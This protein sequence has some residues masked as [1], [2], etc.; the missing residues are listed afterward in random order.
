MNDRS[1]GHS[2]K[3]YRALPSDE[4]I[5]SPVKGA[6]PAGPYLIGSS[7]PARISHHPAGSP[8]PWTEPPHNRH[9]PITCKSQSKSKALPP[10]GKQITANAVL[11]FRPV[12]GL[13]YWNAWEPPDKPAARRISYRLF[14]S[15]S[16]FTSTKVLPSRQIRSRS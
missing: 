10:G 4:I 7:A 9:R 2:G 5:R 13:F 1:C 11:S 15:Y 3:G 6:V 14:V 12:A 8:A 16:S